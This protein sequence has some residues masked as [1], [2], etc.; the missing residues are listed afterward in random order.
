MLPFPAAARTSPPHISQQNQQRHKRFLR[1]PASPI[2]HHIRS[3]LTGGWLWFGPGWHW[4][5]RATIS[6]SIL[7]RLP[8]AT[9]HLLLPH[10]CG[11]TV[12]PAI[13]VNLTARWKIVI[14]GMMARSWVISISSLIRSS[15]EKMSLIRDHFS[16]KASDFRL[17]MGSQWAYPRLERAGPNN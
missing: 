3:S 10:P 12:S 16:W 14:G 1:L 17:S 13:N 4:V 15:E 11:C 2:F 9:R 6:C 8:K 7:R 5:G